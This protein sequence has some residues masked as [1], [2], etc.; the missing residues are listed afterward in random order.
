[1]KEVTKCCVTCVSNIIGVVRND[2]FCDQDNKE[3]YLVKPCETWEEYDDDR[4]NTLWAVK[5]N[6]GTTYDLDCFKCVHSVSLGGQC[7]KRKHACMAFVEVKN[8]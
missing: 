3:D 5:V 6:H 4:F 8:G 1:M 7:S 2:D